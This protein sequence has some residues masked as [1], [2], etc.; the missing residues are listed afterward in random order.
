MRP[1]NKKSV[2][3]FFN[4][5]NFNFRAKGMKIHFSQY[6]QNYA[7]ITYKPYTFL[8]VQLIGFHMMPTKK[9]S[10]VPFFNKINLKFK[11]IRTQ[12]HFFTIWPKHFM[13]HI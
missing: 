1:T 3:P 11:A 12:I 13:H 6:G 7:W 5:M 8:K 10:K 9:K 2:V 4:K